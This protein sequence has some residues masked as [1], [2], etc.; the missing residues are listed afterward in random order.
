[1]VDGF[2]NEGDGIVDDGVPLDLCVICGEF[3]IPVRDW[4]KLYGTFERLLTPWMSEVWTEDC[5][6]KAE[7]FLCMLIC[8]R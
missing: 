5:R 6:L 7:Y 2:L 8:Q 1:M 3:W 4:W